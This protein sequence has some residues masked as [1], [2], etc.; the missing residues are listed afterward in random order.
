MS[1]PTAEK[2]LP[3]CGERITSLRELT[4]GTWDLTEVLVE[5]S[6]ELKRVV[7]LESETAA[8][9]M[10]DEYS[11]HHWPTGKNIELI[12]AD[13]GPRIRG[14]CH[15]IDPQGRLLVEDTTGDARYPHGKYRYRIGIEARVVKI[16]GPLL[17]PWRGVK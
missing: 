15:G 2:H 3:S 1:T 8:R 6:R 7:S 12:D 13:R 16:V 10:L 9:E 5:I 14:R 17:I 4:A 11:R